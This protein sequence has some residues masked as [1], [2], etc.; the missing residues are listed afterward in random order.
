MEGG[1]GNWELGIGVFCLSFSLSIFLLGLCNYVY[2][3]GCILAVVRLCNWYCA[4]SFLHK[5][6][7]YILEW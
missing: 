5:G 4:C 1:G 7:D 6:A 2:L 3:E